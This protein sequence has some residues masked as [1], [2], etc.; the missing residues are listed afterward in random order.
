VR[1]SSRL[2]QRG[3]TLVELLVSITIG[4]I[5]M[6]G[7]VQLYF[8]ATQTQRSQEGVAR[9]QENMRYLFGVMEEDITQAGHVGCLPFEGGTGDEALIKVLLADRKSGYYDFENFLDGKDDTG[10]RQSDE[11]TVRYF[12]A[13]SQIPLLEGGMAAEDA[14]VP[15]NAADPRYVLLKQFDIAL[16]TDCSFADIFMITNDPDGS[17]LIEHDSVT[18]NDGQ[19]NTSPSFQRIYGTLNMDSGSPAYIYAG[20][21]AAIEW[22]LGTS[23]AGTAASATCSDA[24]PQYCALLRNGEELA[25]GVENLQIEYGWVDA[26]DKLFV[27]KASAVTDWN[28]VDRVILSLTLNSV[29]YA[30]TNDG[31][32]L[33]TKTISKTFMLR[34]QLPGAL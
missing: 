13:A 32:S 34:N 31:K 4:L 20:S 3:M 18:S 24:T 9:I 23:A 25:E 21:A 16:I 17:G 28:S 29:L 7:V 22:K 12:S 5:I 27:G 10:L 19:S 2:T 15:L 33:T 8:T 1:F 26:S 30:P 11:L 6:A 14:S